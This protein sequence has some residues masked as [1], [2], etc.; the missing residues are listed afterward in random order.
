MLCETYSCNFDYLI[1]I[2]RSY[3][4][5][6]I[7]YKQ[8]NNYTIYT[9]KYSI[10]IHRNLWICLLIT[11]PQEDR[12]MT[13]LNLTYDMCMLGNI[14]DF[15]ILYKNEYSENYNGVYY[16]N[17]KV[18]VIYLLDDEGHQISNWQLKKTAIHELTHHILYHHTEDYDGVEHGYDFKKLFNKL[19]ND[20]YKDNI[21]Q[22]VLN[23]IKEEEKLEKRRYTVP[24][25]KRVH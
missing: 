1:L 2:F 17:H 3:I 20:Y 21:P 23:L 8:M 9:L 4:S 25:R 7:I 18:A 14:A 12:K 6:Y 22:G 5:V 19:L 13:D 10:V 16:I 24:A 15:L 11:Y